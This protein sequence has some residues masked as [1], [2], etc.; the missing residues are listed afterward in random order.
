M[1]YMTLVAAVPQQQIDAIRDDERIML[2]PTLVTGVSHLLGYWIQLQPLGGLLARTINGGELLNATFWHPLRPPMFHRPDQVASIA[3]ELEQEWATIRR[4]PG[5]HDEW[6]ELEMERLI[7]VLTHARYNASAV[8]TALGPTAD[9]KRAE[10][11]RIPWQA[12][13]PTQGDLRRP[14]WMLWRR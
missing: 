1:A 10:R 6:L 14:W 11:I 13:S 12:Y 9:Q 8:V 2:T 4:N 5:F 3:C 7:T